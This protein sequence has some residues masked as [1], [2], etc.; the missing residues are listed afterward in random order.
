MLLYYRP[1][2]TF[3]LRRGRSYN[4]VDTFQGTDEDYDTGLTKLTEYFALMKN[5]KYEI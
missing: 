4:I 2:I 1:F 3:A 5:V